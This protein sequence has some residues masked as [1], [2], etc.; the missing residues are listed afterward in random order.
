MLHEEL[1]RRYF[2]EFV[3]A[4]KLQATEALQQRM[5]VQM[6]EFKGSISAN[7]NVGQEQLGAI[8]DKV[9]KEAE[10]YIQNRFMEL[11]VRISLNPLR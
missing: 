11:R 1:K 8:A 10:G 4:M 9:I 3:P 7:V 5:E 2:D 6:K